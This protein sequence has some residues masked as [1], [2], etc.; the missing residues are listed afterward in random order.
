MKRIIAGM[1]MVLVAGVCFS[2]QARQLTVAVSPFE[3]R[4]GVNP[5]DAETIYEIFVGEL[6]TSG[7]VRV[8]DRTSFDAIMAEQRFQTSDWSNS[9]KVA[10]LGRALNANS[11]IRGQLMNLQGQ[12]IIVANIVDINTAQILSSSRLQLYDMLDALD[13]MPEFVNGM[14]AKLPGAS[15]TSTA[16]SG[17]SNTAQKEYK[18]GDFGP[19]GGF[20]FYDKGVLTNGW[21]YLEAAPP[22]TQFTAQWG[23]FGKDV[24]GT[25]QAVG[26]GKRNTQIIVDYLKGI[27]ERGKAA[28]LCIALEFEGFKD[29][30]LP[31]KEELDLMYTN[32]KEKGLGGFTSQFYWSSSQ[33][34]GNCAWI[35]Y[36]G[37]GTQ[38]DSNKGSTYCVRAVR[39]F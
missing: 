37:N 32:L 31:S 38:G 22:E 25:S 13:Q 23:A 39:A 15:N 14:V 12:I 18:I 7:K 30:F 16:S 33:I 9:N 34:D 24:N 8:V 27:G 29:W 10:Q 20:I 2:Q 28:Q 5:G 3:V 26:G 4:G 36:F 35:Q 11:I 21:R 17:R 1:V 19:A 6:V